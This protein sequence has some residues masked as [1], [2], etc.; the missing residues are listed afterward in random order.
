MLFNY[1]WIYLYLLPSTNIWSCI[2]LNIGNFWN[3]FY[4]L[5]GLKQSIFQK[6][7]YIPTINVNINKMR[8]WIRTLFST[9]HHGDRNFLE[10]NCRSKPSSI[11]LSHGHDLTSFTPTLLIQCFNSRIFSCLSTY[12][13]NRY[14]IILRECS[15]FYTWNISFKWK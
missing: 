1:L 9:W 5:P 14:S 12:K 6:S 11:L 7:Y 8:T 3:T 10:K 2:F 15:V 4:W 13:E